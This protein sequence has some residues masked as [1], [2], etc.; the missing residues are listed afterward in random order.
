MREPRR[1]MDEILKI[2]KDAAKVNRLNRL[3]SLAVILT[4]PTIVIA[5]FVLLTTCLGYSPWDVFWLLSFVIALTS[6]VNHILF[7]KLGIMINVFVTPWGRDDDDGGGGGGGDD[8]N[9]DADGPD[10]D[11][12]ECWIHRDD[13]VGRN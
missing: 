2:I 1:P 13:I 11:L 6:M 8:G 7:G 4:V 3:G 12:V 5:V 10:G 9:D